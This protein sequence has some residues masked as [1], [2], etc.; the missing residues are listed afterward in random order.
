MPNDPR[1]TTLEEIQEVFFWDAAPP[2]PH[3]DAV[4]SLPEGGTA[5]VVGYVL[6]EARAAPRRW[7]NLQVRTETG[8]L[9]ILPAQAL[10][11]GLG[12]STEPVQVALSALSTVR[13]RLTRGF[14]L[15]A[16]NDQLLAGGVPF[17][18]L[19]FLGGVIST[20][21]GGEGKY[22]LRPGPGALEGLRAAWPELE[23]AVVG[24]ALI[25]AHSPLLAELSPDTL[26]R[27][28]PLLQGGAQPGRQLLRVA[29]EGR[30][31]Q[32]MRDVLGPD[33]SGTSSRS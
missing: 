9:R 11:Q 18:S 1:F 22:L 10:E 30:V 8:A 28:Q 23:L 2:I 33:L 15:E 16:G 25:W 19:A 29:G 27:I 32:I 20:L 12:A 21:L 4:V 3:V 26:R 5:T 24:E 14:P 13:D 6:E 7:L 31:I 17:A